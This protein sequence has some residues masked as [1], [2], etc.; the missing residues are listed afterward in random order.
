MRTWL[1]ALQTRNSERAV[2]VWAT[3]TDQPTQILQV[4]EQIGN[5]PDNGDPQVTLDLLYP[6]R[7]H[8]H[9]V[10]GSEL[11][12]AA[13][14][15]FS[16]VIHAEALLT[17]RDVQ[18]AAAHHKVKH[19]LAVRPRDDLRIDAFLADPANGGSETPLSAL[20]NSLPVIDKPSVL[21]LS[22]PP[23]AAGGPKECLELTC[24]RVDTP[25]VLAETYMLATVHAAVFHTAAL[26]YERQGTDAIGIPPFPTLPLGPTPEQLL[27]KA[28]TGLRSPVTFRPDGSPSDR[29][30]GVAFGN[31]TFVPMEMTGPGRTVQ[32]VEG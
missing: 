12:R 7:L 4:L 29:R 13:D 6:P 9:V 28:V 2:S 1:T 26:R 10:P 31:F 27:G 32:V 21:Y 11:A 22:R 30:A 18:L 23:K 15:L 3:L 20:R 16:W 8:H 17:R 14:V 5:H 24:L 25:S 19:G